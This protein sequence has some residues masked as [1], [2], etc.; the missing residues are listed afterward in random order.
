MARITPPTPLSVWHSTCKFN[1]AAALVM[2]VDAI[3]SVK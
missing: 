1:E 3:E 2:V